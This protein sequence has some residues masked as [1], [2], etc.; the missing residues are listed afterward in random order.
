MLL[1]TGPFFSLR[2]DFLMVLGLPSS[3]EHGTQMLKF[4]TQE[5]QGKK[6]VE[7][8]L[9]GRTWGRQFE[10]FSEK[11]MKRVRFGGKQGVFTAGGM[12]GRKCNLTALLLK[13]SARS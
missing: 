12:K 8:S 11:T 3:W 5:S 4:R 2:Y 7:R 1:T 13:Y 10:E 6:C 9:R